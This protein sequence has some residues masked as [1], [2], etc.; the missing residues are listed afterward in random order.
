M[1]RV[2]AVLLFLFATSLPAQTLR[3][4]PPAPDARTPVSV[5]LSGLWGDGCPPLSAAATVTGNRINVRLEVSQFPCPIIPIRAI[6]YRV[7]AFIVTLAPGAYTVE[8]R[9]R[10]TG[11]IV[12]TGRLIV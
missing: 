11:P 7:S 12:T 2:L 3:F 10:D 1:R 4:D 5:T 9:V 6:E 8:A